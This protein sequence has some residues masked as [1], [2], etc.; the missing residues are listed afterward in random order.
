MGCSPWGREESD[1]TEWLHLHSSLSYIGEGNGNPLQC[2]CLENP[3]HEGAWWAAVCGVTQSQTQ[4]KWLSSSSISLPISLPLVSLSCPASIIRWDLIRREVRT[5]FGTGWELVSQIINRSV[6]SALTCWK[7]C[8]NKHSFNK[9]L[10]AFHCI[11]GYAMGVVSWAAGRDG[12]KMRHGGVKGKSMIWRWTMD[13]P[14]R[15]K[16]FGGDLAG[17]ELTCGG[18]SG[19]SFGF[20]FFWRAFSSASV[21]MWS[22]RFLVTL[23]NTSVLPLSLISLIYL[24]FSVVTSGAEWWW[25]LALLI[26]H[27]L[28][29]GGGLPRENEPQCKSQMY[30]TLI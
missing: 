17:L 27:F 2:S 9:Y 18:R 8:A 19:R 13:D 25:P 28:K 26:V 4:P 30:D 11:V 16:V 5:G 24:M 15:L 23:T 29:V 14:L 22:I 20:A 3:R 7:G 10:F 12:L 6:L 21:S 1:T